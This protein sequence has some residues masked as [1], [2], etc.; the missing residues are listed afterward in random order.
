MRVGRKT[1]R[2]PVA[3]LSPA[4]PH[5]DTVGREYHALNDDAVDGDDAI[6]CSGGAHVGPP[7]WLLGRFRNYEHYVRVI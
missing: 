3:S 7:L 6:K 2:A 5:H 4:D 1:A